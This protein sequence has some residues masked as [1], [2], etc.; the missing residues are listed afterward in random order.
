[1]AKLFFAFLAVVLPALFN[2]AYATT[3]YFA[4]FAYAGDEAS[5]S[6]RFRYSEEYTSN[7]KRDN[8]EVDQVIRQALNGRPLPFTLDFSSLGSLK[9]DETLVVAL[10]VNNETVSVEQFGKLYKVF[11]QV[12]AQALFFD[13]KTQQVVS[14]YP[15]SFAYL[16]LLD[17]KPTES[18]K[19]HD[20]SLVYNGTNG[21]PGIINRFVDVL[22]K[23]KLPS[24][25]QLF[26]Q[27]TDVKIDPIALKA[28]PAYLAATPGTAETWIADMFDESVSAES[29]VP[30]LPYSKGYA[31]GNKMALRI[32]DSSVFNLT[33]PKPDYAFQIEITGL[34]RVEYGKSEAG[35]SYIYASYAH[36]KLFDPLGNVVALDSNFKNGEIKEVPITQ[37]TID[38]FPAYVDSINGLF[39]KLGMVFA[40]GP[41]QWLQYA[42]S[43]KN[44]NNQISATQKVLEK[45]K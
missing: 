36:I 8:N 42:A 35:A 10:I 18:E 11:S 21:K 39:K 5:F 22:E 14:S 29:E 17:H 4:G 34:K 7:L 24:D 30:I 32:G 41:D 40:N 12:R 2:S 23:A 3:V 27:V 6:T 28:I 16:D 26:L 20:I 1:M 15:F 13:Y 45:C 37:V 25:G 43:A 38:D 44:I 19:E 31:I 9:G 33:L